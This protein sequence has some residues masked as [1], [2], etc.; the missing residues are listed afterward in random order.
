MGQVK[1]TSVLPI[2]NQSMENYQ[3]NFNMTS[4]T[5]SNRRTQNIV[6]I[7]G[8]MHSQRKAPG[9]SLLH[10]KN[11][12]KSNAEK[13]SL[14]HSVQIENVDSFIQDFGV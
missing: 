3:Q 13:M 14:Y 8:P 1:R 11:P 4:L 10:A 12:A 9:S 7:T 6:N 2:L 5:A